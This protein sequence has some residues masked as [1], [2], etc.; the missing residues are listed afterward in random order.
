MQLESPVA[1]HRPVTVTPTQPLAWKLPYAVSVAL[2]SKKKKKKKFKFFLKKKRFTKK[3][4][5]ILKL[6][7]KA[8]QGEESDQLKDHETFKSFIT[9]FQKYLEENFKSE[10]ENVSHYI[11]DSILFLYI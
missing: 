10:S 7:S 5:T 11:E 3:H 8:G 6:E 2:K 1:V 4:W 9:L